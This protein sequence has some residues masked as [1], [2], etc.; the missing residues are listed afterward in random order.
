MKLN[1]EREERLQTGREMVICNESGVVKDI[2]SL[3]SGLQA[4]VGSAELITAVW[5]QQDPKRTTVINAAIVSALM[6]KRQICFII[7]SEPT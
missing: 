3:P 7:F 6:S 1:K 4:A 2:T 5:N